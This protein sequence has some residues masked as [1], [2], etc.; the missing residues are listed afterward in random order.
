MFILKNYKTMFDVINYELMA[1]KFC[2]E[3]G[4]HV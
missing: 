4:R 2:K 3:L 1:P